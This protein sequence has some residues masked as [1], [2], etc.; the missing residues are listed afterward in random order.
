MKS[1]IT[2]TT[3]NELHI[4]QPGGARCTLTFIKKTRDNAS[5]ASSSLSSFYSK[6]HFEWAGRAG[7]GWEGVEEEVFLY[8][9]TFLCY[10]SVSASAFYGFL[11]QT[12]YVKIIII[13][14]CN[15]VTNLN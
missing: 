7:E 11:Q 14:F 8:I 2:G 1:D 10:F 5:I 6:N 13:A 12:L 3:I 9:A 4:T 15:Y